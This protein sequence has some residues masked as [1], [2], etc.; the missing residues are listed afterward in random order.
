MVNDANNFGTEAQPTKISIQDDSPEQANL[1]ITPDT[2]P[3][4]LWEGP[5]SDAG[6]SYIQSPQPEPEAPKPEPM[7]EPKA[8]PQPKVYEPPTHEDPPEPLPEPA[9]PPMDHVEGLHLSP[10]LQKNS[11]LKK[12]ILPL[13]ILLV[14]GYLAIDSGLI[15]SG[16]N[17]PFHIFKQKS[18]A[19]AST[20]AASKPA[21]SVTTLPVGFT[22]YKLAGTA[23]TFAAP[24][25]WGQPTS[26]TDP[27]YSSRNADNKPDGTH[28]FLVDFASNKDIQVAVTSSKYLPAARGT[29]YY[30]Y[31]QWCS[32]TNDNKIYQSLLNF[33]TTNKTDT[34]TTI[35]CN[36]GP[37]VDAVKLS[38]S[39]ILQPNTKDP[40]GAVLGDLYTMNLSNT[41]L[42]VFRVKDAAMKNGADIK[43][44]LTTVKAPAA[45]GSA[46]L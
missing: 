21:S 36:Q 22:E 31:L 38:S 24:T 42:P 26:T 43:T 20:P 16:L 17:L 7:P 40:A 13:A 23:V 12:V 33:T 27:G 18:E 14:A 28:A 8:E 35:S 34:P 1:K 4:S 32:G 44:L 46:A 41:D 30:D 10:P 15:N 5:I 2:E 9:Q 25:S 3:K 45:S 19:P 6:A 39:T 11:W 29:Q 37:L